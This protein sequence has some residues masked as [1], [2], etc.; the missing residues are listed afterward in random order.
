MSRPRRTFP[1]RHELSPKRYK[2]TVPAETKASL[3]RLSRA[4]QEW[5]ALQLA[6]TRYTTH[7]D[8][9][10]RIVPPLLHLPAGFPPGVRFVL[11]ETWNLQASPDLAIPIEAD[12]VA[13]VLESKTYPQC[14]YVLA[15]VVKASALPAPKLTAEDQHAMAKRLA[16]ALYELAS[17][18]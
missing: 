18:S 6:S 17:Q 11:R 5:A 1:Q 9:S 12:E 14:A 8:G 3:Q 13:F 4:E 7:A 10:E 16:D 15:M 2:V